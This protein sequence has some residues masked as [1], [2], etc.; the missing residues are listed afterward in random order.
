VIFRRSQYLAPSQLI[1]VIAKAI[2]RP[3]Q[4]GNVVIEESKHAEEKTN[5]NVLSAAD[6]P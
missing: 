6:G 1:E 3:L 5:T 4:Y 2:E